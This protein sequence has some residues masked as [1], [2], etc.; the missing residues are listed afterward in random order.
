[1]V[2][3]PVTAD[4]GKWARLF[5]TAAAPRGRAGRQPGRGA[6]VPPWRASLSVLHRCPLTLSS[7]TSRGLPSPRPTMP[8]CA[9]LEHGLLAAGPR[10]GG[11]TLAYGRPRP[12]LYDSPVPPR[13]SLR[14]W[15]PAPAPGVASTPL[16]PTVCT[17][18][19]LST[20]CCVT[21]SHSPLWR[22]RPAE[23]GACWACSPI[24]QIT[25]EAYGLGGTGFVIEC[26]TDNVNRSA[27]DVKAAITKGGGKASG[28]ACPCWLPQL[29]PFDCLPCAAPST[30]RCRRHLLLM[31]HPQARPHPNTPLNRP[32]CRW[33][34][35]APC[36]LTSSGRAWS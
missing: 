14:C 33:Q 31:H 2:H 26:L 9:E 5:E 25:Y 7:V 1:M 21:T 34:T 20:V 18:T 30:H 27:S 19:A 15:P 23:R 17:C 32:P 13:T 16:L 29:P 24:R 10:P 11:P 22:Y 4:K 8:R 6:C 12:A 3:R 28:A 36:C 35:P